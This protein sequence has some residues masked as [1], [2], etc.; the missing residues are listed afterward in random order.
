MRKLY[1]ILTLPILFSFTRKADKLTHVLGEYIPYVPGD[2][3]VDSLFRYFSMNRNFI[4]DSVTAIYVK[5]DF[6]NFV[7]PGLR[8]T[9]FV[10]EA[11]KYS[12]NSFYYASRVCLDTSAAS[13]KILERT[14]DKLHQRF[15][16]Q[17]V[18]PVKRTSMKDSPTKPTIILQPATIPPPYSSAGDTMNQR[19]LPGI[20]LRSHFTL[21]STTSF[22]NKKNQPL[23]LTLSKL[24][25]E[26]IL[27]TVVFCIDDNVS[28]L[29]A[30]SSF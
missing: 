28:R 3:D 27:H 7:P 8:P 22:F 11:E 5:G 18:S 23:P 30:G 16:F 29:W 14:V 21:L 20:I 10:I 9:K 26:K 12:S 24:R 1:L 2:R 17:K 13:K 19:S 6:K 15:F 25:H 4:A